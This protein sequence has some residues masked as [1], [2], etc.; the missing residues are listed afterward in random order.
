[1]QGTHSVSPEFSGG[2]ARSAQSGGPVVSAGKN[3]VAGAVVVPPGD[4]GDKLGLS[5]SVALVAGNIVGTGIFLLPASLAAIGTVSI[6]VLGL[7]AVGAI[8]LALVFGRL[9]GRIPAGGGPYAYTRDAFGEFAGF[10]VSW[11]FWLTA[12]L[13]NAGIAY[14]WVG[15]VDYFLHWDGIWGKILIGLVGLWIPALINMTGVRNIGAFQNITTILKFVPLVFVGVAGLYFVKGGNF[16]AFNASGGSLWGAISLAAGLLLFAF[17]GV[18]SA[19]IVAE[20]IKDP[21]RDIGRASLYGVLACAAMYLLTTIAIFG[22]L[23]SGQLA[24][25][26]APFADAINTMF[27]GSGWGGVLAICAIISGIGALNGWTMLVAEMPLAAARDGMFPRSFA[28]VS[29]RGAPVTGI[30]VGT[31]LT[32]LMVIDAYAGSEG[33]FN[34]ILLLASF[35][36]ALPYFFSAAAQLFWLTTG[37]RDINPG[38]MIRDVAVAGL[39]LIFGAWIVYGAGPDAALYGMLMMLV[40]VPVYL[41]VKV[42]R[43]EYGPGERESMMENQG[44]P[45]R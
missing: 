40:G 2:G 33:G 45:E 41:W 14:A 44:V 21:V 26:A 38:R 28:R 25:S 22:V 17:S 6:L 5:S 36:T 3:R 29:R 13:G 19:T 37:G 31:T 11:S 7:V 4:T 12:W 42:E 8:A 30:V 23:P 10:W 27:G 9:G 24:R 18:E 35:T 39:A 1:M 43:G 34:T 32:S 20:K 16:P 15:Y